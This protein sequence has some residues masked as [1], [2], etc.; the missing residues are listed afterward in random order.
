MPGIRNRWWW[1]LQHAAQTWA[2]TSTASADKR[3]GKISLLTLQAKFSNSAINRCHHVLRLDTVGVGPNRWSNIHSAGPRSE[4]IVPSGGWLYS[5]EET[6][7]FIETLRPMTRHKTHRAVS[8]EA[9][10]PE[11][12]M[13]TDTLVISVDY[14]Q[15]AIHFLLLLCLLLL[16]NE[17]SGSNFFREL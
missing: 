14:R 17:P 3:W 15:T 6:L 7:S 16:S 4:V 13:D 9:N 1:R 10:V 5:E 2:M 11:A 12:L 8:T